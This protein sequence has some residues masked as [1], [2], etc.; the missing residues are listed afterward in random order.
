MKIIIRVLFLLLS[1]HSIYAQSPTCDQASAMC[2]GQGGPYNNTSNTTPGGNQTG[3]GAITGCG[4]S[5]AHGNNGSLGSTPRP[6]WFYYTIGQSGP[7]VLNLVQ[8]NT[9][10]N[11]I[12]VD[13]ALWGPFNTTNLANI[14][15]SLSG[16]VGSTYTGP[17]NLVDASYSTTANENIHIPNAVSGEIYL[18]LVT[19]FNGAAGTYTINQ[20]NATAPGAGQI[21]CDRVCGID[22]GPDRRFCTTNVNS[23]ELVANFIQAPTTA[24]SPTYS[25]FFYNGTSWTLQATTSTNRY[26]VNQSGFWRV[27]VTRPGCF[28]ASQDDIEVRFA[29]RPTVNNPSNMNAPAGACTHTFDL[30]QNQAALTAPAPSSNYVIKYYLDENDCLNGNTNFITNPTNYTVSATTTIYV[31][32]E[33]LGYS[34]CADATKFFDLVINCIPPAC[35]LNLTSSASTSNQTICFNSSIQNITYSFGGEATSASVTGLPAGLTTSV[36]T[37]VLTISGT[38]TQTGT[39]NYTI[40]SVGCTSNVTLPGTITVSA[41]PNVTTFTSNSPI[42]SGSSAQ[43]TING[44]PGATIT[45]TINNGS[46]QTI[47]LNSSGTA[48]ITAANVTANTTCLLSNISL[49]TCT[50]TLTN[51]QTVTVNSIPNIIS[52]TTNSPVCSGNNAIFTLNGTPNATVTYSLNSGTATTTTLNST[53]TATVTSSAVTSTQQLSVT[54]ITANGCSRTLSLSESIPI[55]PGPSITNLTSNGSVCR[56]ADAIFTV[57]GTVGATVTYTIN[58]GTNQ[59]LILNNTGQGIVTISNVQST[60]T[61]TLVSISNSTCTT[62]LTNTSSVSLNPS[63]TIPSINTQYQ[64]VCTGDDV[65]FTITGAANSIVVYT[66]NSGANQQITL[67]SSGTGTVTITNATAPVTLSLIS[68]SLS[69]CTLSLTNTDTVFVGPCAIQKGISPNNDGLNE[70]F[71]LEAYNVDKLEI[72]NRY[73]KL[74][75]SKIG[76]EN[77]WHGQSDNGNELPDGTYYFVIKFADK[78][79][80]TGWIYINR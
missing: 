41:L 61:I 33:N 7:I 36:N 20:T 69:S 63:P 19:N 73:G 5:N 10:G 2:S 37:G 51:S 56:G 13:F 62:S 58:S 54:Q 6:A 48:T 29:I 26:T 67:N 15:N 79:T 21:S 45:Y 53:G 47:I 59:T 16:V 22:L 49:G 71:D 52:I 17:C 38:P 57:T 12:D 18:L 46:N 70:F 25:W 27:S 65:I 1:I 50:N 77:E 75:Y 11:P 60:T 80:K 35:Q 44:T 3:I 55:T 66:I 76:Y 4:T 68:A 42:C 24:G 30:T 8:T 9:N 40:S 74:V 43:F 31:R 39:F 23:L 34:T 64:S 14:C 28:D 78:E 72:Y 32:V